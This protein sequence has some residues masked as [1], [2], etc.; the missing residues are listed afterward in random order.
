M[1]RSFRTLAVH[2]FT[3]AVF[4]ATAIAQ[5]HLPQWQPS[6]GHQQI[7][8]WPGAAPDPVVYDGPEYS[9][10]VEDDLVAA[11]PWISD[12]R[13]SVPTMTVY[14]PRTKNTGA[15]VVVFPGGG[16]QI[17]AMD[18]EGTEVC[19]WLTSRGITCVLL[20]YRVPGSA[21]LPKSGAYPKAPQALDD[22]QTYWE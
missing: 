20:K 7:P 9:V 11:K 8:I 15:A 6:P 19:D 17:L 3:A 4:S 16:Y 21:K 13:V 14:P 10:K 18:L 5:Q 12:E 2:A 1:S 22:A